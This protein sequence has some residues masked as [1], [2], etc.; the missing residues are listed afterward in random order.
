MLAGALLLLF[1]ASLPLDLSLGMRVGALVA[2]TVGAPRDATPEL[3]REA[4]A[5]LFVLG[6]LTHLSATLA[7]ASAGAP[8]GAA[9]L[10]PLAVALR[11]PGELY[12]LSRRLVPAPRV[13]LA[14]WLLVTTALG[15]SLF[16]SAPDVTTPWKNNWGDLPFHLGMLSSFVFGPGFPPEYHLFAG[17]P[18]SYPFFINLWTAAFWWIEPGL[19]VLRWLFV[20]Q[21]VV[22]WGAVHALLDG[23]RNALLPWAL[24]LGGGSWLAL[25]S[26]AGERIAQGIAWT[27]F[28]PTIWVTQRSALLG[29]CAALACLRLL[30][31]ALAVEAGRGPA[32]GLLACALAGLVAGLSPLAHVHVCLVAGLYALLVLLLRLPGSR[33][34]LLAFAIGSLPALLFLPWL[35]GKAG[36]VGLVAG[37][38]TGDAAAQTGVARLRSAAA[39][40]ALHAPLFLALAAGLWAIT[41]S[42]AR[43]APWWALFVLGNLL[44]LAVWEW[45]QLKWFLGLYAVL[46]AA[47]SELT[48]P[49]ARR[50]QLACVLLV[51]PGLV[52]AVRPFA[53]GERYV[54]YRA[55]DVDRA[56]AVR[57]HTP[58]TAIIACDPR[59]N[60]P[61]TLT[62]RSLFYGY[63]ATL[64]SHGIDY[65]ARRAL[66][67]DFAALSACDA[68]VCPTHLFWTDAERRFW[69][70]ES[71]GPGFLPTPLAFL[72]EASPPRGPDAGAAPPGASPDSAAA[73]ASSTAAASRPTSASSGLSKGTLSSTPVRRQSLKAGRLR[74]HQTTA[75]ASRATPSSTPIAPASPAAATRQMIPERIIRTGP[76]AAAGSRRTSTPVTPSRG[77]SKPET[78]RRLPTTETSPSSRKTRACP[79]P[80]PD[81][82]AV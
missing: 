14:L 25:G 30:R 37:F 61:V 33:H 59:H 26:N 11:A 48:S 55:I 21:W 47:W 19:G 57:E 4:P 71:P 68:P 39:A 41:R 53:A 5:A 70:R 72:Y 27:A 42:H 73:T 23:R 7:L 31:G 82:P 74:H 13:E 81:D 79:A 52:E 77:C 12:R 80:P 66:M 32:R 16:S 17:V 29:V 44:Q 54:V 28:L 43:F 38:V 20:G 64:W 78:S 75:P 15:V 18:L 8:L 58:P 10:L 40:W 67:A 69:H 1:A 56:R 76:V 46:L 36:T 60:S 62:G 6:L 65:A 9:S 22:L 3:L 51:V 45:D 24:L 35:V 63:E 34:E 50:A 49:A 2:R